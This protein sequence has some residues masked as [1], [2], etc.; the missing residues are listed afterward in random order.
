[1]NDLHQEDEVGIFESYKTNPT[2]SHFL[3]KVTNK[4]NS[5]PDKKGKLFLKCIVQSNT[6]PTSAVSLNNLDLELSVLSVYRVN[7]VS[8]V[9]SSRSSVF[10]TIQFC[11]TSFSGYYDIW[12]K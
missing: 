3:N 1:M 12:G 8:E 10:L 4:Q 6:I 11:D 5:G 2:V 7:N 9:L